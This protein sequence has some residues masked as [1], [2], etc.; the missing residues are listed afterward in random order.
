MVKT[1]FPWSFVKDSWYKQYHPYGEEIIQRIRPV[2]EATQLFEPELPENAFYTGQNSNGVVSVYITAEALEKVRQELE[3]VTRE[4]LLP[5]PDPISE[6]PEPV[7]L[8]VQELTSTVALLRLSKRV[9]KINKRNE[10]MKQAEEELKMSKELIEKK[11]NVFCS[12][13]IEAWERDQSLLLEIGWS[14]YDSK[15]DLYMDQHYLINTYKHLKNGNFVEDNK[16]RF[17]FGTSV[18]STLPQALNELKKDLDWAV[19]RDGEVILIGHGFESDLKYLSKH[20]FRW[21]GTRP[22]E[23]DS[24]DVHKSAVTWILNTDT[25]YAA[26]IHDLHNPPS[27]GKTLK[28]FDIDTWCLHNAGNDAH[29]T[30]QLFLALVSK[31]NEERLRKLKEEKEQGT[32]T[33]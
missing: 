3:N 5:F 23:N 25:L 22:G 16:L 17:Q 20:K 32:P 27:L 21:P 8:E 9:K 24:E 15:T 6:Q 1:Y 31:E 13:D 14:M 12:I 10:R 7:D 2:L 29:Y 33:G 11:K 18:W 19:E 30:L 28:L 26:S 4:I